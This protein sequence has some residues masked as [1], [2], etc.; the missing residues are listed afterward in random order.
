MNRKN[1]VRVNEWLFIII[2]WITFMNLYSWF[3]M[4]NFEIMV[5]AADIK[6]IIE[7]NVITSYM[8]SGYQYLEASLFGLIFGIAFA[9]L[10]HIADSSIIRKH[11]F[12]QIIA[13]KSL[14]YIF[15]LIVA[16]VVIYYFFYFSGIYPVEYLTADVLGYMTFESIL[17]LFLFILFTI[18]I[19]NF[20]LQ[21]NRKFGPGNLTNMLMGKYAKPKAEQRI[22]MFLD[23]NNSTTL[24]ESLGHLKYSE[25]IQTCYRDLTNIVLKYE[26]DIYQYV[27]DEVVLSWSITKGLYKSNC[28]KTFFAYERTLNKKSDFYISKFGIVPEFKAGIDMGTVTATEI[29]EIKR[30]IAYHGDV[31]NT[32]SRIQ[33]LCKKLHQKIIVTEKV[34]RHLQL[35]KGFSKKSIGELNLRGKKGVTGLYSIAFS[36]QI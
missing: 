6:N 2:A 18:F 11:S 34:S 10:E 19:M 16:I 17:S 33:H 13:F 22:F 1:K 24:A 28:I 3:I 20:V 8:Y 36:E 29:G 31:L 25:L 5:N 35:G 21:V 15:A 14:F 32:A 4:A 27:G 23:L 12:G 9:S 26:A 30:E 7:S